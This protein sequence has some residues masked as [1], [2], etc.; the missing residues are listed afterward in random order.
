MMQALLT[1]N[2]L[3]LLGCLVIALVVPLLDR[4]R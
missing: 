4:K 3:I 1:R 2:D